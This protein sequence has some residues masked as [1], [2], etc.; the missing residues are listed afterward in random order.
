[1]QLGI[2]EIDAPRLLVNPG[3]I[4]AVILNVSGCG[5]AAAPPAV[6]GGGVAPVPVRLIH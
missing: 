4:R 3:N 5:D 6:S 2:K 1:M